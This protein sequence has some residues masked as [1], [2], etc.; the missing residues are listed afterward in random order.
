MPVPVVGAVIFRFSMAEFEQLSPGVVHF[1]YFVDRDVSNFGGAH[2]SGTRKYWAAHKSENRL[3]GYMWDENSSSI[4]LQDVPIPAFKYGQSSMTPDGSDWLSSEWGRITG[5]TIGLNPVFGWTAGADPPT[6]PRP[7]IY[8]AQLMQIGN[9]LIL[10]GTRAI[11]NPDHAWAVPTLGSNT[12]GQLGM[13][14]AFGGPRDFVGTTVGFV[15]LPITPTSR[16]ENVTTAKG[17]KG[18]PRSG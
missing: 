5:A 4:L 1:D 2:R 18:A 14:S 6:F 9:T 11:W 16:Y 13:T 7:F 15:E 10:D 17:S 8:L 3:R 12:L